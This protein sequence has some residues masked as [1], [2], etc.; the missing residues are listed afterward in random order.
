M[1]HLQRNR[2][3]VGMFLI[4]GEAALIREIRDAIRE[5]KIIRQR[6]FIL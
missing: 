5:K 1:T 4:K 2:L 3:Y 6:E